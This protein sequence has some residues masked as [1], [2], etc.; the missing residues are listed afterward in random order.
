MHRLHEKVQEHPYLRNPIFIAYIV[1]A[2]IFVGIS[3]LFRILTETRTN[4]DLSLFRYLDSV[5]NLS[6]SELFYSKFSSCL[7]FS[8]S[9]PMIALPSM[10]TVGVE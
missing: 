3:H 9:K 6:N 10:T 8:I 7:I 2:V 5:I 1:L 4:L